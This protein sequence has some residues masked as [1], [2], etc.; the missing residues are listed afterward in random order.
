MMLA[1]AIA[2]LGTDP[3]NLTNQLSTILHESFSIEPKAENVSIK[4]CIPT[5]MI[6]SLTLGVIESLSFLSLVGMII[7]PQ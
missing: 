2:E 1:R 6:N 3:N 5:T 7:K 4:N